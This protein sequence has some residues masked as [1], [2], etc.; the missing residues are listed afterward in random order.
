[1][2][3]IFF[4]KCYLTRPEFEKIKQEAQ[5]RGNTSLSDYVRCV[6]TGDTLFIQQKIVENNKILKKL[7]EKFLTTNLKP[8]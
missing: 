4:V 3:R 6:L 2:P 8:R 7:E 1:M 5:I